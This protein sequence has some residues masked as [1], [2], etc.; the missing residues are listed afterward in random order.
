VVMFFEV[1]QVE[2][3]SVYQLE[4][5]GVIVGAVNMEDCVNTLRCDILVVLNKSQNVDSCIQNTTIS[6]ILHTANN[7]K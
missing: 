3:R 1:F 6:F 5:E 4:E 7:G 2:G